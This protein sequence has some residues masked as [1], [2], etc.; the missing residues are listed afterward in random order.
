L[1]FAFSQPLGEKM[2]GLSAKQP[3]LWTD[4]KYVFWRKQMKKVPVLFWLVFVLFFGAAFGGCATTKQADEN[5]VAGPGETLVE[6]ERKTGMIGAAVGLK[7]IIDGEEK[8]A[9]RNNRVQKFVV[10]NGP[11]TIEGTFGE[12]RSSPKTKT[13]H[14]FTADS[15]PITFSIQIKPDII[16]GGGDVLFVEK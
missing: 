16:Q 11:H 3:T 14:A 2:Q 6:L 1:K 7:I 5:L 13:P 9:I 8:T 12:S 10:P 4:T 15:K